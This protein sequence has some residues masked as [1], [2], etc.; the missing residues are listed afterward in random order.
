MD[1]SV[2][3]AIG[4]GRKCRSEEIQRYSIQEAGLIVLVVLVLEF[5]QKVLRSIS[6]YSNKK[7]TMLLEEG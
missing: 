6:K 1:G 4:L 2:H 5:V 7:P 3:G